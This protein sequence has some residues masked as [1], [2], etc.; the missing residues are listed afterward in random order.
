[1]TKL[2]ILKAIGGALLITPVLYV[3]M[4]VLLAMQP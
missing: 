4:V 2:D 3:F 1:M